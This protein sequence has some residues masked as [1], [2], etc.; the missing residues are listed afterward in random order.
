MA[1][2]EVQF[3]TEITYEPKGGLR[4]KTVITETDGGFEQRNADWSVARGKWSVSHETKSVVEILE[5]KAFF[6]SRRGRLRG[7]RLKDWS[8]YIGS[9]EILDA[10]ADGAQVT[11]Q[12]KRIYTDSGGFTYVRDITKTVSGTVTVTIDALPMN[13]PNSVV[14]HNNSGQAV[15]VTAPAAGAVIGSTFQFDVPVRFDTDEEETEVIFMGDFAGTLSWGDLDMV[16][17]RIPETS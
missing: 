7:F 5:L 6:Y 13:Q 16:E 3:P 2:D 4:F 8:D 9:G 17:L 10:S 1:F 12:I 14:V 11:F 15:F